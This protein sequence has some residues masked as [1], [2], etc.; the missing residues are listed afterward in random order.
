[1]HSLDGRFLDRERALREYGRG[2]RVGDRER[3][4]EDGVPRWATSMFRQI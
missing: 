1:M 2:E 4:A 3:D